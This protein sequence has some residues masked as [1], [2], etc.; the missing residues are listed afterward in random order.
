MSGTFNV[1]DTDDVTDTVPPCVTILTIFN[2]SRFV[3]NLVAGTDR[4]GGSGIY[5]VKGHNRV[6]H[7]AL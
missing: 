4:L 6:V 7:P 2:Q 3:Q 5:P 1:I